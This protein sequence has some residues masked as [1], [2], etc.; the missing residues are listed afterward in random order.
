MSRSDRRPQVPTPVREVKRFRQAGR[1][2]ALCVSDAVALR[3]F[4]GRND[5]DLDCANPLDVPE[6]RKYPAERGT[7]GR[8]RPVTDTR[9]AHPPPTD[10]P[11]C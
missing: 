4:N 1:I 11:V 5:S 10:L 9:R 2:S 3:L 7:A 6:P 8:Y